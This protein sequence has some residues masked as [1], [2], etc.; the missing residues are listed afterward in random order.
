[1]KTKQILIEAHNW[2]KDWEKRKGWSTDFSGPMTTSEEDTA[3]RLLTVMSARLSGRK[4]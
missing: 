2:L 4:I 1:M 3:A